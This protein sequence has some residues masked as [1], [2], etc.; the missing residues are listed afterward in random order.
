MGFLDRLTKSG[1][2]NPETGQVEYFDSPGAAGIDMAQQIAANTQPET[3]QLDVSSL[4]PAQSGLTLVPQTSNFVPRMV[5]PSFQE[6]S[7]DATGMPA[8][9][10]P[11]LTRLG[12]LFQILGLAA[13][14]AAAGA[15][16]GEQ[17]LAQS[18]GR[19]RG[20]FGTGF[21]AGVTEPYRQ[22]AMQREN[23]QGAMQTEVQRQ[24][25]QP[26]STP[27]GVLPMWKAMQRLNMEKQAAELQKNR[28][29]P[30]SGGRG[31]F[32]VM[33]KT[34]VPGTEAPDK[35]GT[36]DQQELAARTR[37]AQGTPQAGDAELVSARQ[38]M[39]EAAQDVKPDTAAVAKQAFQATM[40]KIAA[41]GL[42]TPT[43]MTSLPQLTAA[44]QKSKTLSEPER[45]AALSYLSSTPTPASQGS[46]ANL[47]IEGLGQTRGVQSL[48]DTKSGTIGPV[49]WEEINRAAVEEPGR[50]QNPQFGQTAERK[51]FLDSY[52]DPKG[53]AAINRQ[54]I[55]N[56]LQH[57]GDLSKINEEYRRTGVKIFNTPLNKIADQFGSQVFNR[58]MD[59]TSVL[60]DEIGLYF[61][62]GYAP[63]GDQIA[64]WNKILSDEA[65]PSAVEAFAKEM[66]HLGL[67]RAHTFNEGFKKNM[68]YSDPNMIVPEAKKAADQLGMGSEVK[69]FGSGGQ[70]TPNLYG[71]KPGAQ[72]TTVPAAPT[73]TQD[74]YPGIRFTPVQ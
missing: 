18:G 12:K 23:E 70:Y 40:Q 71:T 8:T 51:K 59:V 33:G 63:Q 4:D 53:R 24:Q 20:G 21:Q 56:I 73:A 46:L 3:A 42:I 1:V 60:K 66:V 64:R 62:G 13:Q 22:A 69:E 72:Q 2:L 7:T 35:T 26:V 45:N 38:A 57:A 30:L 58:Y 14:G 19:I 48:L 5:K 27:W 34:T 32:D 37:I 39:R 50:Y 16:A 6:A 43:A 47:R 41:E 25:L 17:T 52:E 28:Y 36:V 49:T 9:K 54:A 74:Q 68:G 67:R 55:N 31:V 65:P 10:T 11:G 61:A 15:A 29:L 44:V